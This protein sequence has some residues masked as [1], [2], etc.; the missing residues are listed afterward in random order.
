M[1]QYNSILHRIVTC[2][3]LCGEK[4]TDA[5][6]IDKTLSTFH[7]NYVQIQ[8]QYRQA[9]YEKYSELVSVLMEAQGEDETLVENHTS[10]P[11]GSLAVPEV[12]ANSFKKG[13]NQDH[14]KGSWKNGGK[15]K[16]TFFKK[17]GGN[18]NW[19]PQKGTTS[20]NGEY[21]KQDQ[22]CFKCGT[23]GHWSRICRTPKHLIELYQEKHGK[24][25][26]SAEHESHFTRETISSG[27]DVLAMNIDKKVEEK[28]MDTEMKLSKELD[29][30]DLLGLNDNDLLGL[31]DDDLLEEETLK[32]LYGDII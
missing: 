26:P 3:K 27:E 24:R 16:K 8:R 2:L 13:K 14:R 9:K 31:N 11:T 22:V 12:H 32:E 28:V 23:K 10:R 20:T 4:I 5:D 25:K 19:K 17:K 29:D 6:M 30:D 21:G 15:V 7:P 1:E 18:R